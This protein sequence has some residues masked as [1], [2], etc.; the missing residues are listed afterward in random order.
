MI[1]MSLLL[2]MRRLGVGSGFFIAA[3]V[4]ASSYI[5]KHNDTLSEI[6][7][8][9]ARGKIYGRG[10]SLQKLLVLNPQIK[11]ADRI[12]AG[13]T[14]RLSRGAN[15]LAQRQKLKSYD[16]LGEDD[17]SNRSPASDENVVASAIVPAAELNGRLLLEVTP[18]FYYSRIDATELSNSSEGHLLSGLNARIDATL[19]YLWS[20]RLA[21]FAS[22][23]LARYNFSVPTNVALDGSRFMNTKLETGIRWQALP[24]TALL[25]SLGAQDEIFYR[26]TSP[27]TVKIDSLMVPRL[28]VGVGQDIYTK[29]LFTLGTELQFS[30]LAARTTDL[31]RVKAGQAYRGRLF[32]IRQP[33]SPGLSVATGM[34][35]GQQFQNTDLLEMKR[36]DLGVDFA[37]TWSFGK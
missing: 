25:V 3:G 34:F 36:S 29:G 16:T 11:D 37:L 6:A 23:G 14:I 13:Q 18:S 10:G 31:Y 12:Y 8:R 17:L 1:G 27:S 19:K 33:K 22:V 32:V 15:T 35:Y 9:T 20:E 4:F 7:S 2:K 28:T 26:S 24:T 30:A 5:V 21:S